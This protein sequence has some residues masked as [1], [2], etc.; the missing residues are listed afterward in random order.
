M[1][2]ETKNLEM[3][4]LGNTAFNNVIKGQQLQKKVN[5]IKQVHDEIKG[6]SGSGLSI[7]FTLAHKVEEYIEK[8]HFYGLPVKK[9]GALGFELSFPESIKLSEIDE[10][11]SLLNKVFYEA[12]AEM[13]KKALN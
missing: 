10:H 9:S 13:A 11:V 8:C 6:I 3:V 4:L 1:L 12:K 7:V 2:K 5:E